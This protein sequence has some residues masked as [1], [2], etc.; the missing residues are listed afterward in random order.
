MRLISAVS[1]DRDAELVNIT[2]VNDGTG[3]TSRGNYD[4]T[5]RGRRNR[6]IKSGRIL[7]WPRLAKTPCA[8]L[9]RVINDAYPEKS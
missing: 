9:Q 8:L 1:C 4:Y 3:T 7:N 5:I 2:I 6:R